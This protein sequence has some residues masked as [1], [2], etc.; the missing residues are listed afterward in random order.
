MLKLIIR[1]ASWGV[2]GSLFSFFIG[3]FVKIYV[4]RE[5]GTIEWGKYTT[6]HTFSMFFDTILSFGIPFIILR[7]FPDFMSNSREKALSI[8]Q[9]IL[10][11]ATFVS[12][13]FLIMIFFIIPL[14]DEYVYANIDNFS[15]L[16]LIV[17]IHTPISIF[18][19]IIISLFRSVLKIKEII[20]YGTFISVPLRAILTFL[21]FQFTSD[22]IFFVVIELFTQ[23]VILILMYW[24]FNKNVMRFFSRIVFK[25]YDIPLNLRNYGKKMYASSIILF[26]SAQSLGFILGIML[27]PDKIGVYSILL[28]ITGVSLFLNKNLRRIYAPVISKLYEKRD[29]A[30][31][32]YLYKKTTFIINLLTLPVAILIIFFADEILSFFSLSGELTIYKP[33]LIII[34]LARIIPLLVGQT[35]TFMVMAGLEQKELELQFVKAFFI[36]ILTLIFIEKYKL[37]AV[38]ILYV[39]FMLFVNIIQ[40]FYIYK[41]IKISPFSKELL[42]LILVS[43]PL[44]WV[45]ISQ[46]YKFQ[47]YHYFII[48]VALY[49]FFGVIFAKRI[50]LTLKEIR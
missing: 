33:Y 50:K 41:R 7:F 43:F 25:D 1:Q 48:P 26:L 37:L 24:I 31:L 13:I 4:I 10:F 30:Q 15:Y 29:F 12:F 2:L 47:F 45:S 9:K 46:D 49:L 34:M 11:L 20:L 44:I 35:G 36:I 27:P 42:N 18:M 22:I 6:A 38:V 39:V 5:V 16:L 3:F 28:T 19:G 23:L 14:L 8:I 40:L 17:S 21:V 32:N